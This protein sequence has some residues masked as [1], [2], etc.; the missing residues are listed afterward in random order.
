MTTQKIRST[1]LAMAIS[2]AA[3][4]TGLS[5]PALAEGRAA[6]SVINVEAKA[7]RFSGAVIILKN[8]KP[9]VDHGWGLA[10]RATGK[11]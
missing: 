4:M 8:G 2:L 7:G 9:I 5:N 3:A 11:R 10:D 1:L 6:R